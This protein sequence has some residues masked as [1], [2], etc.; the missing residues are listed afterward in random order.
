MFYRN[1][2]VRRAFATWAGKVAVLL[3]AVFAL[4]C[5]SSDNGTNPTG[6]GD[7]PGGGEEPQP[8]GQVQLAGYVQYNGANV[9]SVTNQ[10]V[11]FWIRDEATGAAVDSATVN[12]NAST[13][14]YEISGLPDNAVGISTT[15]T[16]NGT[17]ETL[18]GNYRGW[19]TVGID[20]LSSATK[21]NY[22]LS[23]YKIIHMT[24]PWDNDAVAIFTSYLRHASPVA[25]EWEDVTGVDHYVV[26]IEE[27]T[28]VPYAYVQLVKDETVRGQSY[29]ATLP[30]SNGTHYE[31]SLYGY[32]AG[33]ELIAMY[34]TTYDGGYGSDY[35]FQVQ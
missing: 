23:V 16:V 6:G 15:I 29:D 20:T 7:D 21:S 22:P 30:V 33:G 8:G 24:S 27:Y 26:Q 18:P 11:S 34:M 17:I 1:E 13:G 14:Y 5:S 28:D 10:A 32:N 4:A 31:F 3:L 35:R 25:F 9:S 2:F 12:Y 19:T